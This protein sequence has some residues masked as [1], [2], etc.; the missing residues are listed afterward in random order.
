VVTG[1]F[2]VRLLSFIILTWNSEKYLKACIDSIIASCTREDIT[3]EVIVVDNGSKDGSVSVI[4]TYVELHPD[5]FKLLALD[6][7]RGTTYPRNLGLKQAVGEYICILDSDTELGEGSLKQVL[8]CLA[9]QRDVGILAPQ[10]LLPDGS[11]QNSVKRFPTMLD[12]LFKVPRIVTNISK[13][14]SKHVDQCE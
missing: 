5:I 1:E 7:N 11:V 2:I 9:T 12:K 14:S 13:Y 3:F 10:L 8:M 4:Q 6:S